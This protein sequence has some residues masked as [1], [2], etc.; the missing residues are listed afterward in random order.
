MVKHLPAN[1]GDVSA[2]P[3]SGTSPAE[4][5]GWLPIPVFL[6]GEF[7]GQKSLEGYSPDGVIRVRHN[8]VTKQQQSIC[9]LL[10]KK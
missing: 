5:N 6:P 4:G 9:D 1:G 7:H 2:I 3:E 10:I 8:L